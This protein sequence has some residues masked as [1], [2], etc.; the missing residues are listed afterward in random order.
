MIRDSRPVNRRH[1]GMP[2]AS[3]LFFA[4]LFTVSAAAF[5]W[6]AA[7]EPL[8]LTEQGGR[9]LALWIGAGV[10]SVIASA[11]LWSVVV[12]SGRCQDR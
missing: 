5:V 8:W 12:R 6:I 11:A 9:T 2:L 3:A 7:A 1:R 4:V 10:A